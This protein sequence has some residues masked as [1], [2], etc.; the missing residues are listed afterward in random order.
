MIKIKQSNHL[1]ALI[2]NSNNF[3]AKVCCASMNAKDQPL[4]KV[5]LENYNNARQAALNFVILLQVEKQ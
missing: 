1:T 4:C 2:G 3:T 5:G